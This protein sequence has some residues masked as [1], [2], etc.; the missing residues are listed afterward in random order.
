MAPLSHPFDDL[1]LSI[2]AL[3]YLL[4]FFPVGPEKEKVKQTFPEWTEGFTFPPALQKLTVTQEGSTKYSCITRN[5]L[6]STPEAPPFMAPI[7]LTCAG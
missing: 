1:Q 4:H 6:P 5:A 2:C 7:G 3:C